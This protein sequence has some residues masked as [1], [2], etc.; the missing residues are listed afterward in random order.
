MSRNK[1]QDIINLFEYGSNCIQFDYNGKHGH[2]DPFVN[3]SEFDGAIS[4]TGGEMNKLKQKKL[5]ELTYIIVL[6]RIIH[7]AGVKI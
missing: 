7:E 6:F 4:G 5:T 2:I 1:L 3:G